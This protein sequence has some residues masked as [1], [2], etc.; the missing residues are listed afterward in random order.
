MFLRN[1]GQITQVQTKTASRNADTRRDITTRASLPRPGSGEPVS[2]CPMGAAGG[3]LRAA[4]V[5]VGAVLALVPYAPAHADPARPVVGGAALAS[6]H[7]QAGHGAPPLPNVSA[8]AWLVADADSGEV[9]GARDAH[10]RFLPA[11]TMK[12]LTAVSVLPGLDL[13]KTYVP[14]AAEVNIEGSKVGLVAGTRYPIG[15]LAEAML[16]VSGNDAANALAGAAGGMAATVAKM[17]ATAR[18]LQAY[19]TLAR[20]PSGLDAP[21][22]RT[23]AYDLALVARAGLA[24]PSFAKYARTARDYVPAPG[25]GRFEIDNHNKL[26]TR[27]PGDIGIKTGYTI[28][29]RHT[30]V[31]AARR[32]GH[33]IVV[34]LL[35]AETLYP[36][37]TALLDW[38]FAA[39]GRAVPLGRLVDPLPDAPVDDRADRSRVAPA[40]PLPAPP[41]V[42]RAAPARRVPALPA[43]GAAAAIGSVVLLRRRA[44]RRGYRSG[45][46]GLTLRLP[47]R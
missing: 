42:H 5:A 20:N 44:V 35:K 14:T 25:G 45:R 37:A 40:A 21:D 39:V 22:Q 32:N 29:A 11:S 24:M 31:G 33:T 4:A 46:D 9:L 10:G 3:R 15:K 19:D 47:V 17:N 28:A 43:T 7:A 38:G 16:V 30:Y 36:D 27:Y 26:L 2:S 6:P 41:A 1:V 13:N 23:S 34:T 8:A 12:T 18:R